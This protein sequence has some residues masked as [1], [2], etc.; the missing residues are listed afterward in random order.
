M[1]KKTTDIRMTRR[2]K[3]K[4]IRKTATALTPEQVR[5]VKGG[6]AFQIISAGPDSKIVKK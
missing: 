1:A 2:T 6:D 4:D 5:K 3:V